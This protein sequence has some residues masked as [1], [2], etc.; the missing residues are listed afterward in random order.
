MLKKVAVIALE[1]IA[2]FELGVLC[3]VFGTDR[4]PEFPRYDFQL[5]T[6]DGGPVTSQ[7]GYRIHPQADLT[8]VATA[9]LVA[10]PAHPINCRA[11]QAVLDALRSAA[12][13]GALVLS[14]CSGA[15]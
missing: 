14:V 10:V 1:N 2:G 9:D 4:G 8:P 13:R 7:S 11:P 3:E 5:C 12:D 6:V 15:F